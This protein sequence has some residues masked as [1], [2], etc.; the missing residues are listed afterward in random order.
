MQQTV[1][2]VYAS[3]FSV[4]ELTT[5]YYYCCIDTQGHETKEILFSLLVPN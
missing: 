3:F 1:C 2:I 4:D 5:T